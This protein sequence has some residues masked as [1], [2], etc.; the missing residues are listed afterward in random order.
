[1]KSRRGSFTTDELVE[2]D[3]CPCDMCS[4]QD[5]I[6]DLLER[7]KLDEICDIYSNH[8]IDYILENRKKDILKL[9]N[10]QDKLE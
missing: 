1:M 9:P 4:N 10:K 8:M 2:M 5:D 7:Q 6:N 3:K